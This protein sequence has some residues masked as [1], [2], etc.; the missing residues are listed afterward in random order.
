MTWAAI[1]LVAAVPLFFWPRPLS[2]IYPLVYI[3]LI[4]KV[5]LLRIGV[6][7]IQYAALALLAAHAGFAIVDK[8]Y[9]PKVSWVDLSL[10]AFVGLLWLSAQNS[11]DKNHA[12]YGST[13]WLEGFFTYLNYA[14]L[15]FVARVFG[16]AK[17]FM[18]L[19]RVLIVTTILISLYGIV[20]IY[21]PAL[22]DFTNVGFIGRS[23]STVGNAV[24]FGAYLVMPLS[25][26]GA[27]L[28]QKELKGI[29]AG[30]SLAALG[31]GAVALTF[32]F[33]R[34]AWLAMAPVIGVLAWTAW[35]GK[36]RPN[37]KWAMACGAVAVLAVLTVMAGPRT[38]ETL[39]ARA[40]S[41]FNPSEPSAQARTDAWRQAA[42]VIKK[43]PLWGTGFDNFVAGSAT[44]MPRDKLIEI[45]KP[46]NF[47]LELMATAGLPA[48]LAYLL[49]VGLIFYAALK[50][51]L[52]KGPGHQVA[53]AGILAAA[54]HLIA[55]FFLFSSINSA[56]LF[57]VILGLMAAAAAE[58]QTLPL[59]K[60]PFAGAQHTSGSEAPSVD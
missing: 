32:T 11:L 33:S 53:L 17:S 43:Y 55:L 40:F 24:I 22:Q 30:L 44:V 39:A 31:L 58:A 10:A 5:V 19:A 23:G 42:R 7:V 56:P 15:F 37:P 41:A 26:I 35:R 13:Y 4:P 54:S 6:L 12:L 14:V 48:F 27:L 59:L 25:L 34:G 16:G 36:L 38:P 45:D 51:V 3:Y 57:Y 52:R 2:T 47:G 49:F 18:S 8:R 60:L 50:M 21:H 9:L 29:W 28:V 1:I 46:H 20:E